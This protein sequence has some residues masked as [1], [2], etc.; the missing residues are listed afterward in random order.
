MWMSSEVWKVFMTQDGR[1]HTVI[2]GKY[3]CIQCGIAAELKTTSQN[4]MH[5]E[6]VC[7]R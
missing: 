4:H 3:E 1:H 2:Q 6:H 7:I 5:I